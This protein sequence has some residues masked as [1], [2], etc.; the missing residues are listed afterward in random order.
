MADYRIAER[1]NVKFKN[2]YCHLFLLGKEG[3]IARFEGLDYLESM[4]ELIQMSIGKRVGDMI[5]LE[6]TSAQKVV[7][8]HL[9][10]S[11][12][13]DLAHIKCDIQRNV[14]FFDEDGNDLMMEIE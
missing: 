5:G 13:D 11:S 10:L 8:L 7:S 9:K 4:P 6:G 12:T 2:V 1:D 3:R 14:H